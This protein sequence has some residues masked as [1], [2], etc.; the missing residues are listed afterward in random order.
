MSTRAFLAL[1]TQVA[2]SAVRQ[3]YSLPDSLADEEVREFFHQKQRALGLFVPHPAFLSI[4][5]MD[6]TLASS[7]GHLTTWDLHGDERAMLGQLQQ[8]LSEQR[9][10]TLAYWQAINDADT[11][12]LLRCHALLNG[13]APWDE[14]IAPLNMAAF[15]GGQAQPTP[16]PALLCQLAGLGSEGSASAQLARLWLRYEAFR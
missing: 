4:T 7:T 2:P 16:S 13:N 6:L 1:S 14:E 11:L 3:H 10:V 5:R 9:A 15:W 8:A 12:A